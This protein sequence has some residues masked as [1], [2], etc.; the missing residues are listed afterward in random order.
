MLRCIKLSADILYC[1]LRALWSCSRPKIGQCISRQV[2]LQQCNK[3]S[4]IDFV[5]TDGGG[6]LQVLTALPFVV[7]SISP[8][9]EGER[10]PPSEG[11]ALLFHL[12]I[13]TFLNI[14]CI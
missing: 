13:E 14:L 5:I 10:V 2:S 6:Y 3:G 7:V 8:E 12:Q 1:S 4:H 11:A 9:Q